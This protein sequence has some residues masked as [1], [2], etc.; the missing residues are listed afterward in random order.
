MSHYYV[1]HNKVFTPLGNVLYL[2]PFKIKFCSND[3]A[4]CF[5]FESLTRDP[6]QSLFGLTMG[7]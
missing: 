5:Y 2:Y 7:V 6:V 4:C 1:N 3:N